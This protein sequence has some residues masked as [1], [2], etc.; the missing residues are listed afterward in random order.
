VAVSHRYWLMPTRTSRNLNMM[1]EQPWSPKRCETPSGGLSAD[2][3]GGGVGYDNQEG[4]FAVLPFP[5]PLP[6]YS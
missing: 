2:P 6:K 5:P 3:L 4:V 1:K